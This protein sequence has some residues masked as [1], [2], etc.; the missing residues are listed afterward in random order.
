[1]KLRHWIHDRRHEMSLLDIDARRRII[2]PR[3][4][5]RPKTKAEKTEWILLALC[6][7]AIIVAQ[8]LAWSRADKPACPR[9]WACE[10]QAQ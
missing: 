3:P 6:V 10:Q 2:D 9:A 5:Q 7:V 8:V 4:G 1:M